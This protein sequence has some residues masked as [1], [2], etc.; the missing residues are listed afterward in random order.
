MSH[1]HVGIGHMNN[2][3]FMGFIPE[4]APPSYTNSTSAFDAASTQAHELVLTQFNRGNTAT[5]RTTSLGFTV[6]WLDE[7]LVEKGRVFEITE[8]SLDHAEGVD[9]CLT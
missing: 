1:W 8:C 7:H 6:T 3:G 5:L 9:T 2:G 4:S